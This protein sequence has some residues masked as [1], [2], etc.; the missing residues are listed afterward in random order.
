MDGW[1]DGW[2]ICGQETLFLLYSCPVCNH[3]NYRMYSPWLAYVLTIHPH[4]IYLPSN[5]RA[6]HLLTY[7]HTYMVITHI[8]HWQK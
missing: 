4:V 6:S 3:N 5:H 1:M 8:K 2:M 7:I